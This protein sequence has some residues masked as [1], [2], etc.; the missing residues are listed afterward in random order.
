MKVNLYCI[1]YIDC[2]GNE[3]C[4]E[5]Y[6]YSLNQAVFLAQEELGG[7]NIVAAER[8]AVACN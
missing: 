2:Y 4:I 5:V 3:G 8:T 1:T 7:C 6:A